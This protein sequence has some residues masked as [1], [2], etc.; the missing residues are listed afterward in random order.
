MALTR[1]VT[2]SDLKQRKEIVRG[3]SSIF[4]NQAV[5]RAAIEGRILI[6]EGLERAERNVLPVINNLLE[7]REMALEDGRFLMAP[8]RYDDLCSKGSVDSRYVRVSPHFRVIAVGGPGCQMDPP[9]RS[10]F[11]FQRIDPLPASYVLKY[12]LEKFQL[13]GR[14]AISFQH[15]L[16]L[17]RI[18]IEH[19]ET[20]RS[21]GPSS[22]LLPLLG[23]A[24]LLSAAMVLSLFPRTPVRSLFSRVYPW[25]WLLGDNKDV[26]PNLAQELDLMDLM[27]EP[28]GPHMLASARYLDNTVLCFDSGQETGLKGGPLI[29]VGLPRGPDP[30]RLPQALDQQPTLS[31]LSA[32]LQD[33]CGGKDICIIGKKGEGKSSLVKDFTRALGSHAEL[34]FLYS[35]ICSRDLLQRRTTNSQGETVWQS[36]SLVRAMV[37]GFV[38]V[39]DGLDNVR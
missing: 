18:L 27:D 37:H 8:K 21:G 38:A 28:R 3:G 19:Q 9:L 11:Q 6:L 35:D 5:C 1:D 17:S 20:K 15:L 13:A 16:K 36:T 2:E 26:L 33:H 14:S 24:N 25:R 22:S 30:P 31:I 32:M 4:V 34:L 10:R 7:N 39:L 12:A 29:E 23:E